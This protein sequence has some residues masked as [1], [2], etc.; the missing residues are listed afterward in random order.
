MKK[1][2]KVF[3][4]LISISLSTKVQAKSLDY[5]TFLGYNV[6]HSYVI[7]DYVFNLD[8]GFSPSLQDIMIA[9]RT[10]NTTTE[11]DVSFYDYFISSRAFAQ[12]ELYSNTKIT[13]SANYTPINA[14]YIYSNHIKGASESDIITLS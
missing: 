10:I 9:S 14:K 3:I 7:G 5:N 2:I 13:E 12:T 6:K 8:A 4:L 1:F 11:T